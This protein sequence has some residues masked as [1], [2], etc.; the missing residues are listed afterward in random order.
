MNITFGEGDDAKTINVLDNL[1]NDRENILNIAKKDPNSE[2]NGFD[3]YTST[4]YFDPSE[5][6]AFTKDVTK[7]NSEENTGYISPTARIGHELIHGYNMFNDDEYIARR[8]NISTNEGK[9][10]IFDKSGKN[11]SFTN[12]EEEFTTGLANQINV[13]LRED[14][15]TNYGGKGY[16]VMN[17]N[18]RNKKQ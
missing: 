14:V 7:P 1:I 17:V 6:L 4:V 5:G 11:V 9:N 18:S 12:Q 2:A 3:P 13:N 10:R 15:R 16:K 8:E